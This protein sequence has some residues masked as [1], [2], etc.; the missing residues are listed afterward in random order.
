MLMKVHFTVSP[1]SRLKVA[2]PVR[3]VTSQVLGVALPPSSHV[4][5]SR[6]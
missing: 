6:S 4:M 3:A 1:G 2:V 5:P